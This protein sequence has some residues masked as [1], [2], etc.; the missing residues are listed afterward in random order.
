MVL[1]ICGRGGSAREICELAGQINKK[2]LRWNKVYF[3]GDKIEK[4][5][6]NQTE[7][8]LQDERSEERRVG[9]EC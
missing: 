1:G 9:K 4:K 3:I 8:L 2:E 5:Y 6:I 7:V